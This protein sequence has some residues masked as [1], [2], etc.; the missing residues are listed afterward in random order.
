VHT[1]IAHEVQM[2]CCK[3]KAHPAGQKEVEGIVEYETSLGPEK[4]KLHVSSPYHPS[5][6]LHISLLSHLTSFL[7]SWLSFPI[8]FLIPSPILQSSTFFHYFFHFRGTTMIYC[9]SQLQIQIRNC[10]QIPPGPFC[11]YIAEKI[12]PQI[13]VYKFHWRRPQL[14]K[15]HCF[16]EHWFLIFY[17]YFY[18]LT[19]IIHFMLDPDP[20]RIPNAFRFRKDKK[21]RFQLRFQNTVFFPT[22]HPIPT[23]TPS[24]LLPL[25]AL[26]IFF[27]PLFL[28]NCPLPPPL[29]SFPFQ[30]F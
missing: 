28:F 12:K 6:F 22:F 5:A 10:Y 4:R 16:P 2:E 1:S 9:S 8:F 27:W 24:T 26:H 30:P 29:L 17:F 11:Q 23:T 7:E 13:V 14:E 25:S 18:F 20:N 19:L 3:I 21:L 15:Q